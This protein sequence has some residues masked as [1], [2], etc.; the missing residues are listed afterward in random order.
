MASDLTRGTLAL[1]V[2]KRAIDHH[3][4]KHTSQFGNRGVAPTYFAQK[5]PGTAH[6]RPGRDMISAIRMVV[7]LL[8]CEVVAPGIL[9]FHSLLV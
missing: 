3:P 5:R 6:R 4:V 1:V 9:H 2:L 8:L 7:F